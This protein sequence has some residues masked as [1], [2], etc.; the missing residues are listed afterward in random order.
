MFPAHRN[1]LIGKHRCQPVSTSPSESDRVRNCAAWVKEVTFSKVVCSNMLCTSYTS[2]PQTTRLH[3]YTRLC[4]ALAVARVVTFLVARAPEG[5][6]FSH[7]ERPSAATLVDQGRPW[8][9]LATVCQRKT[10]PNLPSKWSQICMYIYI[11][12]CNVLH[13]FEKRWWMNLRNVVAL[14]FVASITWMSSQ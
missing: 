13:G 11:Y 9:T 1:K 12:V 14:A 2:K 3:T 7:R 6:Y 5:G 10:F 8:H 4:R